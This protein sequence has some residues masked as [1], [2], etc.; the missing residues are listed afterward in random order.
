MF[1]KTHWAKRRL[2]KGAPM[3]RRS[4]SSQN[5][6]ATAA[7]Q[8][9]DRFLSEHDTED[10]AQDDYDAYDQGAYQPRTLGKAFEA[11]VQALHRNNQGISRL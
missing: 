2:N 8:I 5:R 7:E 11:Q 6:N 9:L 3:A 10:F 4:H 1:D